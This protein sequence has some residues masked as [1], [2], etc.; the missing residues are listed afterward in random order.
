[1]SVRNLPIIALDF[2]SADEVHTFLNKFNEPLC[3]KIGMELFYQTGPALIKSIKK[4]GHDIF[5]DLKLHDIPNT[6]SKA[7]EGLARLDIDLVNVHAAGGIKMMEEAKKGLRKHNADIKIIA[8]TQL[9]STTERQLHEEQNIQTSIEEAVLNYARLT[10]KAG[11]DG[12][13]CSPLEAKMISKEL[14]SDFLKV[15]PGTVSYTHLTL[16]TKA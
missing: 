12:V 13:V 10:K 1:M 16:P 8:V 9:T 14:G 4:R 7:M 2:K 6:V 15:T 3:V 5:L 11:L